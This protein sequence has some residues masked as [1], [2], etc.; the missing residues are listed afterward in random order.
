VSGALTAWS[1]VTLNLGQG[2]NSFDSNLLGGGSNSI[3]GSFTYVGGPNGDAVSLDGTT[4]GRNVSVALGESIGSG[5]SFFGTGTKGPG[6]VTVYGN[7]KVTDGSAGAAISLNRLYVG[8]GLTVLAGAGQDQVSMDD[9]N[10][11]GAMLIDL[12][13]GND[14]L[15]VETAPSNGG[16]PLNAVSTIGGTF[17]VKGGDGDDQVDLAAAGDPGKAIQFGGRVVLMGGNGSDTLHTETG[18]TF[19]RTGNT[20]DFELGTGPDVH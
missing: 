8:G 12:G 1:N 5:T 15:V 14:T 17:A 19:E 7:I 9:T 18:A 4:V 20:E 16:G 3:G 6:S 2:Q 10:V 11:A 13:A